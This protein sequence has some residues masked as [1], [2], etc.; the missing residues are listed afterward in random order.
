MATYRTLAPMLRRSPCRQNGRHAGALDNAAFDAVKHRILRRIRSLA[1]PG[2]CGRRPPDMRSAACCGL[3]RPSG[4]I[5]FAKV[6]AR[7]QAGAAGTAE[8]IPYVTAAAR[9]DAIHG[10]WYH[11]VDPAMGEPT[12]V[13]TCPATWAQLHAGPSANVSLVFRYKTRVIE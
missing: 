4:P 6:N 5:D 8:E 12:R 13:L 7:V 3:P 9:C 1:R 11:D 10:G 2:C